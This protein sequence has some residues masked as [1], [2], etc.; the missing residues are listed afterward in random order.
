MQTQKKIRETHRI[1]SVTFCVDH[2][3]YGQ[4]CGQFFDRFSCTCL[5]SGELKVSVIRKQIQVY[6]WKC[7]Y[8]KSATSN[9]KVKLLVRIRP[10]LKCES[11][12]VWPWNRQKVHSD[13]YIV[14]RSTTKCPSKCMY[15][16]HSLSEYSLFLSNRNSFQWNLGRAKTQTELWKITG[17]SVASFLWL[18]LRT[19]STIVGSLTIVQQW[20][21]NWTTSNDV[22]QSIH[23][24]IQVSLHRTLFGRSLSTLNVV[25]RLTI[26]IVSISAG[27]NGWPCHICS[28]NYHELRCWQ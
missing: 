15:T 5:K 22:I 12:E 20:W 6:W 19:V 10:E 27:M 1:S 25:Q 13:L 7:D 23:Q 17:E 9:R 28:V 14:R 21:A 11:F 24:T 4:V 3:V 16:S 18:V 2:T 26:E 8:E